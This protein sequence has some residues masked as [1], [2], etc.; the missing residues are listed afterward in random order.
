MN[1]LIQI[2]SISTYL[3]ISG[4]AIDILKVSKKL[5]L[6]KRS[7]AWILAQSVIG[8]N[9]LERAPI[10]FH[11]GLLGKA[12]TEAAAYVSFHF[13]NNKTLMIYLF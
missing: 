4:E 5:K 11:P 10:E 8:S 9:E 12:T 13:V 2:I 1:V 6:T 7:H 3:L